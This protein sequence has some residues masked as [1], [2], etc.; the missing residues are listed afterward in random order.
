MRRLGP[1]PK[2]ENDRNNL[3]RDYSQ[4]G[5]KIGKGALKTLGWITV[6]QIMVAAKADPDEEHDGI[7][8]FL[9]FVGG[10]AIIA[11]TLWGINKGYGEFVNKE[12][13]DKNKTVSIEV[14][15]HSA[16]DHNFWYGAS[17]VSPLARLAL[18]G[19][20]D[21]V[22]NIKTKSINIE[23]ENSDVILFDKNNGFSI[24]KEAY[25]TNNFTLRDGADLGYYSP[26]E[27]T[28]VF[29]KYNS[30]KQKSSEL[31]EKALN[32]GNIGKV[33]ELENRITQLQNDYELKEVKLKKAQMIA[34]R[35]SAE[36]V[37]QLNVEYFG[38]K[39]APKD[40]A[41]IGRDYVF[42]KEIK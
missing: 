19:T 11:A 8:E 33:A 18:I 28:N 21:G 17:Y 24:N 41:L 38:Y 34:E 5:K 16:R 40:T 7:F 20:A 37:S 31:R 39:N 1:R 36:I 9:T 25:Y 30:L 35:E 10:T 14:T 29:N 6:P 27:V 4:I 12:Y 3:S 22:T 13:S 26:S 32:N 15:H 2:P 42:P 23:I